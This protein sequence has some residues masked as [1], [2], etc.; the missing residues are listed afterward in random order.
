[1]NARALL[2][3]LISLSSLAAAERPNILLIVAEA[4]DGLDYLEYHIGPRGRIGNEAAGQPAV[5]IDAA[6]EVV[7]GFGVGHGSS[8]EKGPADSPAGPPLTRFA[9]D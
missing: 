2:A 3:C 6:D 9:R 4:D 7:E 5:G 8:N 1:M